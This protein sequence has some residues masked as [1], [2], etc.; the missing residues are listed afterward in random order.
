MNYL[1]FII[2]VVLWFPFSAVAQRPIRSTLLKKATI[3]E[4]TTVGVESLEKTITYDRF[5]DTVTIS[6]KERERHSPSTVQK[7]VFAE[8]DAAMAL[9]DKGQI[10]QS[11]SIFQ[12]LEQSDNA[13]IAQESAFMMAEC[14]SVQGKFP[15]AERLLVTLSVKPEVNALTLEKTLVRL[16]H[17][18]CAANKRQEAANAFKRLITEFPGSRYQKIA[19]CDAVK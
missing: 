13:S 15:E 9:F 8:F 16:G 2:I 1:G 12:K 17:V 11:F 18:F 7:D 6:D 14:F 5:K 19:T 4:K 3:S 10:Q